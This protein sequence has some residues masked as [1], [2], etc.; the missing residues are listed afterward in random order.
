MTVRGLSPATKPVPPVTSTV[1]SISVASA[2]TATDVVPIG[3]VT[4]LP[5]STACPFTVN[6]CKDVSVPTALEADTCIGASTKTA[7]ASIETRPR[8][9]DINELKA[10]PSQES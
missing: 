5:S 3:S 4:L 7:A 2:T 6:V 9:R 10:L 1:A 8:V